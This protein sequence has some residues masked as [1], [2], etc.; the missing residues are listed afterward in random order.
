R[1]RGRPGKVN[2]GA[3][4]REQQDAAREIQKGRDENERQ[5]NAQHWLMSPTSAIRATRRRG[6]AMASRTIQSVGGY[7]QAPTISPSSAVLLLSC[8]R[9]PLAL[10]SSP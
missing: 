5:Q 8:P 1:G 9:K 7:A 3:L 6:P 2:Q 4:A 10:G